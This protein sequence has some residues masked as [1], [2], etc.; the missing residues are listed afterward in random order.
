MLRIE[1]SEPGKSTAFDWPPGTAYQINNANPST[2]RSLILNPLHSFPIHPVLRHARI[3]MY[4]N[5]PPPASQP[6]IW[7]AG[8]PPHEKDSWKG[9]WWEGW[10]TRGL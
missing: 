4:T 6:E 5:T 2:T 10:E 9:H 7:T 1:G 8:Q 3:R